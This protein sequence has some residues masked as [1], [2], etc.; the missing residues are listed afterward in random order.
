LAEIVEERST[1]AGRNISPKKMMFKNKTALSAATL[2]RLELQEV[3]DG[4]H[5]DRIENLVADRWHHL[6]FT[7]HGV[8]ASGTRVGY[9]LNKKK[10]TKP[11]EKPINKKISRSPLITILE[12]ALKEYESIDP[13]P[14]NT[15][16]PEEDNRSEQRAFDSLHDSSPNKN[17]PSFAPREPSPSK[18]FKGRTSKSPF[19]ATKTP[20]VDTRP[21][22]PDVRHVLDD[23]KII[24]STIVNKPH[25]YKEVRMRREIIGE[26]VRCHD[27][28]TSSPLPTTKTIR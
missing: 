23:Y 17:V 3:E 8:I 12:D 27:V 11:P 2:Q 19:S 10:M 6:T 26:S 20:P 21:Y 4:V 7:E 1:P 9:T 25:D 13:N 14:S 28:K 24:E 16:K 5:Y 18:T 22:T 15:E